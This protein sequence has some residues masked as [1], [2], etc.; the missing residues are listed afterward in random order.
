MQNHPNLMFPMT[1]CVKLHPRRRQT[2]LN[3]DHGGVARKQALIMA[4]LH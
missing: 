4:A 3:Y 2:L 1:L